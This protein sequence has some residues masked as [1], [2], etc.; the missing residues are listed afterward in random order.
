MRAVAFITA[1]IAIIVIGAAIGLALA[2]GED[3]VDA[4]VFEGE[5]FAIDLP[6]EWE[7]VDDIPFPVATG[8]GVE[9]ED[10]TLGV[11]PENWIVAYSFQRNAEGVAITDDNVLSLAPSL[12]NTFTDLARVVPGGA[13]TDDPV[14]IAAGDLPG[15]RLRLVYEGGSGA[16]NTYEL[17]ELIAD[18]RGYV[19]GCNHS[20]LH[21]EE[22]LDACGVALESFEE[23]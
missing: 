7:R 21:V 20:P 3:T 11:D 14:A 4:S 6:S 23:R 19:I 17:F 22:V 10:D 12:R 15:L 1:G 5:G 8:R 2:G 16:Q 18:D 9:L 13:L